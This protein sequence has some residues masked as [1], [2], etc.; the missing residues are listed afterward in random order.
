[1]D[2]KADLALFE[3]IEREGKAILA[4]DK[5]MSGLLDPELGTLLLWYT[6]EGKSSQGKKPAKIAKWR[7]IV[8]AGTLPPVNEEWSPENQ[9]ELERLRKKDIT[10]GD[11]SYGRLVAL[12]KK[13]L[14]AALGKSNRAERVEWRARIDLMDAAEAGEDGEE[15]AA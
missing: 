10:M 12:K 5:P 15:G 6:K 8:A 13:E 4:L 2:K 1:M 14:T 3:K 11:T 7:A 9:A